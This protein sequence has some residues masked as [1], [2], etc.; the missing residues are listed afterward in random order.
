VTS[1]NTTAIT[2]VL[3]QPFDERWSRLLGIQVDGQRIM[4]R[5]GRLCFQVSEAE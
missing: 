3:T 1:I 5:L 4:C 2:V